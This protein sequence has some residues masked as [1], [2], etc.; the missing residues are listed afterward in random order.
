MTDE[1]ARQI[2]E[3]LDYIIELLD[4][5]GIARQQHKRGPKMKPEL[6]ASID[7]WLDWRESQRRQGRRGSDL[8]L[9]RIAEEGGF[10]VSTLRK[11]S[12]IRAQK[13]AKR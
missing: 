11:R 7:E 10:S 2:L 5:Y 4:A 13:K 8:T 6:G 12:A 9:D 3:K 1:Q